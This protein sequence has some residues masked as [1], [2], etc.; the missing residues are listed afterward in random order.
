MKINLD[1]EKC[2]GC[3][4][5]EAVCPNVFK[6]GDD[7]KVHIKDEGSDDDCIKEAIDICP[8]KA[9]ELEK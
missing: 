2:I 5:C 3:G 1:I 9:I 4:S 7:M 6:M 8:V